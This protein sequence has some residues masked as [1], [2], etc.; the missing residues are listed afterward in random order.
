MKNADAPKTLVEAIRLYSDPDVCLATVVAMRWPN[1]VTCPECGSTEVTFL[2]NQRRWKC[3]TNHPKRQFSVKVG[4]IFED[5][6]IGLDKWLAA[7]WMV[8]NCKNG[9]SS[10][11][12]ARTLGITQKSAWFLNHRI[13]LAM[14]QEGGGKMGGEVEV[15]ETFVGGRARFMHAKR[16]KE[17]IKGTGSMSGGKI[18]V[19]GL[20]ERHGPDGHSRVRAKVVANTKRKALDPVVREHIQDGSTVYTDAHPSYDKLSDAYTHAVIDH[21]ECYAKGAVHTNGIENFWSLLKRAIKGT[22]VSVEPFHLHRYID[23]EAFRFNTRKATDRA[24]FT[25]TLGKIADKRLTYKDLTG[26]NM[27]E[28]S[29][30]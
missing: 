24:R 12:M 26:K 14:Q 29:P 2:A 7:I 9:I 11:E 22:H 10:Y 25:A 19:Q 17:K 30:A 5:S 21:A 20:L 13:R 3:R 15:D 27:V 18:A 16:R 8:A 28:A 4:T 6:P 1:G 23:E